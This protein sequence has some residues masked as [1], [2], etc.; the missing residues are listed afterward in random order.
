[1]SMKYKI[2]DCPSDCML[3]VSV[4]VVPECAMLK[5]LPEFFEVKTG[6]PKGETNYSY[7]S[8]VMLEVD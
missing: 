8:V 7:C 4:L 6:C 5:S 1:M 3:T 2:R